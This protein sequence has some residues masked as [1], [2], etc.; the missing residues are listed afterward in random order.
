MAGQFV[1]EWVQTPGARTQERHPGDMD[2]CFCFKHMLVNHAFTLPVF[3]YLRSIGE[4]RPKIGFS[5]VF[6][7][8]RWGRSPTAVTAIVIVV[9][10]TLS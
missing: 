3:H 8:E 9:S 7:F 1:V 2:Q 5:L 4:G 10:S 6:V